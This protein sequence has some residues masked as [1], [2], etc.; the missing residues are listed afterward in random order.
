MSTPIASRMTEYA[1]IVC[2]PGIV[3]GEPRVDG[4]RIRVRDVAVARDVDGMTPQAIAQEIYPSLTLAEVYAALGYYE[5]HRDEI[6]AYARADAVLVE[7]LQRER[8]RLVHDLREPS[9]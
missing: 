7:Q 2:T 9:A 6:E 1:H 4:H 8:S 5:D 3:G